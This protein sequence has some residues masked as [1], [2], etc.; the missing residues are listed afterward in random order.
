MVAGVLTGVINTLAGSGSL[1]TLPI[2]IFLG[3]LPAPVANGTNRIGALFQSVVGVL[4]FRRKGQ[5]PPNT[6]KS[7]PWLIIPAVLGAAVGAG[8]ASSLDRE[9]MNLTIGGLMVFMLLVLLVNPK[10]W[11]SAHEPDHGRVRHPLNVA[12]FFLIGAYGGFIQAGVGIFLL[13]GLVLSAGFELKQAN[14]IK[15]LIVLFFSLPALGIFFW[16]HQVHLGLGLSMALFQGCGTFIGVWFAD[17]VPRANVYIHRLLIVI[18][19]VSATK[20]LGLWAWAS[21]WW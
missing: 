2:F 11:I 6:L 8:L 9:Q 21:T 10:R 16:N 14:A 20:F 1:I 3:G 12:A 19:V 18:V 17:R 7:L 5:L 4:A 13:A 15:L